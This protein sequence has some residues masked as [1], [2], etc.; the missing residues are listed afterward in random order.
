MQNSRYIKMMFILTTNRYPT[1]SIINSQCSS[2]R[3][4]KFTNLYITKYL[5]SWC[6][7]TWRWWWPYF[8]H[9]FY[10][11]WYSIHYHSSNIDPTIHILESYD[12]TTSYM[13]KITITLHHKSLFYHTDP[14]Y[15]NFTVFCQYQ[16]SLF[17]DDYGYR[18]NGIFPSG[19]IESVGFWIWWWLIDSILSIW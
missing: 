10:W 2:I 3:S 1:Q 5:F 8:A 19:K 18:S 12:V 7:F 6:Y 17:D 14:D 4:S 16:G 13:D 11:K 15:L 9:I